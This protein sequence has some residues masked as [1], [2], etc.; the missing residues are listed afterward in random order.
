MDKLNI[1]ERLNKISQDMINL[2]VDIDYYYGINP[3]SQHGKEMV[4]A[5]IIAK[6][7]ADEM[8]KDND[9]DEKRLDTIGQNGNT[10]EHYT[11]EHYE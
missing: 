3:L 8:S 9:W 7:W 10:G 6:E 5:G 1:I 2:G 11:G 4:G